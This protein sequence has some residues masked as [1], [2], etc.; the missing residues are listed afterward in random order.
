MQKEQ[1]KCIKIYSD[2]QAAI[3]ALD[4]NEINSQLVK[5][6]IQIWELITNRNIHVTLSWIKAH[7]GHEGNE[8][9]DTQAKLGASREIINATTLVPWGSVKTAINEAIQAEWN[10]RWKNIPKHDATKYF[11]KQAD[12]T[13]AEVFSTYV[14]LT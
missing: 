7:V 8:L 4:K 12:K 3:L 2:S 10:I 9:A 1:Y 11:W 5:D 14:V 13:R 6:T